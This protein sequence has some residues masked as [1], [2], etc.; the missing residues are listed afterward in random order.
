MND[1]DFDLRAVADAASVTRLAQ[2]LYGPG[3]E[4]REGVLH[5]TA[6]AGLA[7]RTLRIDEHTPK[8]LA[9]TFALNLARA[10]ADAIVITGKL[11]RDEPALSYAPG[12]PGPAAPAMADYRRQLGRDARPWL[13]VLTRGAGLPLTHPVFHDGHT[14]PLI[15]A[16]AA[17][18]EALRAVAPCEVLGSDGEASLAGLV[19]A[20]RA[21][22]A[23]TISFE[24]GPSTTRELYT[25]DAPLLDELCLSAFLG[26]LPHG[27][28]L[29]EALPAL[30]P[31]L[32]LAGP[33]RQVHAPSGPWAFARY[34]RARPAASASI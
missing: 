29:A 12:S 22:G 15:H 31:A 20:L 32:T 9:D 6:V 2:Q 3:F 23:R 21:R 13:V 5:V 11:L 28:Q 26:T 18:A 24:A 34:V 14:R 1:A 30:P 7:R 17:A 19:A 8:S 16:P 10:R 4:P 25:G 33:E 27:A